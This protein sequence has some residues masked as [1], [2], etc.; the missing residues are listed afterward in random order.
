[1]WDH[2]VER[3]NSK[4]IARGEEREG[5]QSVPAFLYEEDS[6]GSEAN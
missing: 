2:A 1:M 6:P 5:G 3:G 4:L